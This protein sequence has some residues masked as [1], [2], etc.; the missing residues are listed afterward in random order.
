M[1][2]SQE[3]NISRWLFVLTQIFLM[4]TCLKGVGMNDHRDDR[5]LK[6]NLL[7]K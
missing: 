6:Y 1:T 7:V 4:S 2:V 5:Y 3:N